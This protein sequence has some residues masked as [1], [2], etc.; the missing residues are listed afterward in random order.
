M[1]IAGARGLVVLALLGG[2]AGISDNV[3]QPA[4]TDRADGALAVGARRAVE[5]DR[6]TR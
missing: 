6:P 1:R 4:A 5:G 3:V 2:C